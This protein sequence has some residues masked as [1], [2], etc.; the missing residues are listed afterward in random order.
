VFVVLEE[1]TYKEDLVLFEE[2]CIVFKGDMVSNGV[3]CVVRKDNGI[4]LL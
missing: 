4:T 3:K 2:G 1:T